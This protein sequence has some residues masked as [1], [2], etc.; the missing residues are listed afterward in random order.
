M[1]VGGWSPREGSSGRY[2][3][4]G[5]AM[6]RLSL[7]SRQCWSDAQERPGAGPGVFGAMRENRASRIEL[8]GMRR[9]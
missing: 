6:A 2:E 3:G 1:G 9:E 7:S 5:A 8:D 4:C